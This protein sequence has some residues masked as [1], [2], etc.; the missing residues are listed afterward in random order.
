M[1]LAFT[2]CSANYL[3]FAYSLGQT[4]LEHN[5]S[6][7]FI[8]A[9]I[10]KHPSIATTG[11]LTTIAVDEM[12]IPEFNELNSKYNIFELS[13]A[14]KPYVTEF[15][16]NKYEEAQ[17]IIYFDADILV[18]DQLLPIEEQ[19]E[20]KSVILTPHILSP[21]PED[22]KFSN[23]L[24]ILRAGIY[25]AGFF[26][27]KPSQ[28]SSAFIKWWKEKMRLYCFNDVK[29]GLFVDQLWLSFVPLLFKEVF[30]LDHTGCN[31][32][33]W[34]LHERKISSVDGKYVVNDS[35]PLI[36]FHFSGYNIEN[37]S[38]LS[39]HQNRYGFDTNPEL[40]AL[41]KGYSDKAFSNG[42]NK[43]KSIV[44]YYG[45][46]QKKRKG[47]FSKIFGSNK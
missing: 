14:L 31:V 18:Y 41:Y 3:P 21:I 5:P 6:Y 4:I 27:I 10:D 33:Y 24:T 46:P 38:I 26:A 7:H 40:N 30:I 12:N 11:S 13:C 16:L 35:M 42:Y 19:L 15:L 2:I 22:G 47:F 36:F 1:R 44:P 17:S 9:L 29:N 43:Y 20:D 37:P 32:S 28:A 8:I 25:N 34:N 39:V 45:A 23:E